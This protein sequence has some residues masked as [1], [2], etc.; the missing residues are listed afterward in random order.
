[1]T[2]KG[3]VIN[4]VL[5]ACDQPPATGPNDT[6]LWVKR[7]SL[8]YPSAVKRMLEIHPWNFA[9][10]RSLLQALTET[11]IGRT[12]AYNKPGDCLR[13]LTVNTTGD[14]RDKSNVTYEDEG[15]R[16]LANISPCYLRYVSSSWL[17]KEGAWPQVF[18]DAVALG[19]AADSYG[20]FGKSEQ[21]KALLTSRYE[22]ALRTAKSWDAQQMPFERQPVGDWVRSRSGSRRGRFDDC[23]SSDS[24]SGTDSTD[25]VTDDSL[26]GDT[27]GNLD[28][29]DWTP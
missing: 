29:G 4:D 16:I 5:L 24:G 2:T 7:V 26:D 23:F 10:T 11:P 18:A 8:R 15:G 1:M 17:T 9:T 3:A 22:K 28:G 20:V 25:L 21:K 19:V 13:I 27:D 12:Y 6:S 14:A